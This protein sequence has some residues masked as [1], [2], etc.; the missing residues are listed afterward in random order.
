[1]VR[2]EHTS[3]SNGT[4]LHLSGELRF[5]ELREVRAE[6]ER[7]MPA[8]TLDIADVI[9]VDFEGIRWLVACERAGFKVENSAPYIREWMDQEL[10]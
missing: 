10:S 2:I 9:V 1:M 7:V 3:D 6:I 4:T 8:I 5:A